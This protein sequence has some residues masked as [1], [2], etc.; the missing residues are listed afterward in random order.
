MSR[1]KD[2]V[3]VDRDVFLNIDEF[4]DEHDIEGT[5]LTVVLEDDQIEDLDESKALSQ[6]TV[7]L[8]AKTEELPIYKNQGETLYIDDV[9]YT[10]QTWLEEMGITKVTLTLPEG[11]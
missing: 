10:V 11:Y 5:T 6:A 4:G 3:A 2:M 7:I 9:G 8:F 1:F